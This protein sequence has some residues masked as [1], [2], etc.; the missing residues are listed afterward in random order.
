MPSSEPFGKPKRRTCVPS[1]DRLTP[2][3]MGATLSGVARRCQTGAQRRE[4]LEGRALSEAGV[5]A[6]RV[7]FRHEHAAMEQQLERIS[8]RDAAHALGKLAS[9]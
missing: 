4:R 2:S 9:R 1:F 8:R 5:T 6:Q 7:A 3:A